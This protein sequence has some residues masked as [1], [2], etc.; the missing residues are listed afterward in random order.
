M[1]ETITLTS[2]MQDYLEA[3]LELAEK[4]S[5]RI[6]DIAYKLNIAK[7]SVNQT[8]NKL[9]ELGLVYQQAYG[10]VELTEVGRAYANRVKQRHMKLKQFLVEV[11]GVSHETAEKDACLMEHAVSSQTMDRL[12]EFLC[13]NGYMAAECNIMNQDCS[14]CSKLESYE[15]GFGGMDIK[16]DAKKLSELKVGQKCKVVRVSSKGA[17]RRRIMEM[18]ITTGAEIL[19]KGFAPMGDPMEFGIKG[20]SL[21]L[22]K[23]EAADILVEMI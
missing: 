20:Y 14:T 21:S 4:G 11:L 5:V 17:I 9:K 12:T 1:S 23:S 2:S 10:P 19:V 6:T 3:I 22:R 8:V 18:G 7:A 15:K 16:I 13:R